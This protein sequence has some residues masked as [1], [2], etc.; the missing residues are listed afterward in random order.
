MDHK[1]TNVNNT[2]PANKYPLNRIPLDGTIVTMWSLIH[3]LLPT[4]LPACMQVYPPAI[5]PTRALIN[6]TLRIMLTS[7]QACSP[8]PRARMSAS[9]LACSRP[10]NLSA[11]KTNIPP[12]RSYANRFNHSL[13][14]SLFNCQPTHIHV[15]I[16]SCLSISSFAFL[17]THHPACSLTTRSPSVRM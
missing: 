3:P 16:P 6:P 10:S 7:K 9:H 5:N 17:P 13:A 8:V 14:L 11:R 15:D 1:C 4:L 12:A 2:F